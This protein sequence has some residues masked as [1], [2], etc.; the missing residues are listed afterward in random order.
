MS[1][2]GFD[3]DG[4]ELKMEITRPL[5]AEAYKRHMANQTIRFQESYSAGR[6]P[7]TGFVSGTTRCPA[8]KNY[9]A[10][11]LKTPLQEVRLHI[12]RLSERGAW[13]GCGGAEMDRWGAAASFFLDSALVDITIKSREKMDRPRFLRTVESVL[14]RLEKM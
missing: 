7:Y 4:L 3:C 14:K 9:R 6:N 2:M 10:S 13:G 5:S 12:G 11:S 8:E 1:E